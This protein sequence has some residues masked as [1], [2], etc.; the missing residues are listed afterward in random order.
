MSEINFSG[1]TTMKWCAR[2][3]AYQTKVDLNKCC[4]KKHK[5]ISDIMILL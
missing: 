4:Q 3:V 2:Y 5:A 1:S